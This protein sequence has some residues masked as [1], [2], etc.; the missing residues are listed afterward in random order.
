MS[1]G[2]NVRVKNMMY[3]QQLA[4]LPVNTADGIFDLVEKKLNPKKYALIVHD[5]DIDDKG[6]PESPH[7]H[8]MMCFDNARSINN[9][10]KQLGDKPQ[11]I[12]AWKGKAENGFAYLIHVTDNARA[13]H[14]YS[15]GEVKAN[16][17]YPAMMQKMEQEVKSADTYGDS[18]KIKALLN[19]LYVGEITREEVEK[20]LT[21]TQ[22]AKA[23]KQIEAVHAKYLQN[24]A[25]EW[26]KEMAASGKSVQVIWI[27]G[28]AGTGK[29]SLAKEYARKKGQSHFMA[30]SSRDV[31]QM[32]AGEHTLIL[33][34]LRP[35]S[36]IQ[37][38]DLLRIFDPFGMDEQV[39]LPARYTDKVLV[40]DLIIVTSPYNPIQFYKELFKDRGKSIDSFEQLK[41]RISLTVHMT[42]KEI[43]S[44]TFDGLQE[45][46]IDDKSS[47]RPNPY[48][49]ASRPSMSVS[50]DDIY[51]SLFD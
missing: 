20:Q 42:E 12:E 23:Y 4:H 30:G 9:V 29:T 11:Y 14:Q 25:V 5:K 47:S 24:S 50:A 51:K 6:Q 38:E 8:V 40:C 48:S 39:M 46:Y 21:G 35:S 33:D 13:K 31:F 18:S 27:Y 34:E 7:V 17:D 41:R 26:R 32:Y 28:L 3:V 44:A 15:V 16:F 2:N 10:A 19:L 43:L 36:T 49:A 22:Y 45:S 37:Y 1:N